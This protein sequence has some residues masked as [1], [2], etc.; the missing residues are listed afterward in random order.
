MHLGILVPRTRSDCWRAVNLSQVVL[1]NGMR[2]LLLQDREVPLVRGEL[3]MR[4][5]Y[6]ISFPAR[7]KCVAKFVS[8]LAMYDRFS[9]LT[10]MHTPSSCV[11]ARNGDVFL[12]TYF[13][14][15]VCALR[16]A[17]SPHKLNMG[18]L[19]SVGSFE[20]SIGYQQRQ[21]Q[22]APVATGRALLTTALSMLSHSECTIFCWCGPG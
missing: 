16:L 10:A 22:T 3:L 20:S 9:L 7:A 18:L 1:P 5:V 11:K 14:I 6:L 12:I 2:V 21:K 15:L 8:S 4:G 19:R 13:C 17:P